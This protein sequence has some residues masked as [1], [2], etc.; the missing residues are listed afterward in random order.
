MWNM[1]RINTLRLSDG[2][3]LL[4]RQ[5]IDAT[6]L[7]SIF[8]SISLKPP[9]VESRYG[10]YIQLDA[11]VLAAP[12]QAPH[13]HSGFHRRASVDEDSRASGDDRESLSGDARI[14]GAAFA[15]LGRGGPHCENL[16]AQRRLVAW[17]TDPRLRD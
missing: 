1:H 16:A 13:L 2:R 4:G 9:P 14:V 11:P 6:G 3:E 10:S 15:A 17:P 7:A 5:G 12:F 8:V